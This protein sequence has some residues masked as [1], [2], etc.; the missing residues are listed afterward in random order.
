[1]TV[2]G[3]K[4]CDA[5]RE[6]LNFLDE[7][8]VPHAFHDVRADGLDLDTLK[9]WADRVGWEALLNKRSLTWRKLPEVDRR[10]INESKAI[11]AMVDYP[12]LIKRPIF[13]TADSVAVGLSGDALVQYVDDLG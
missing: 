6:T 11:A 12:T 13:E 10:D 7:R 4:S 5:C 2:Y 8:D 9:R 3:L 1:M